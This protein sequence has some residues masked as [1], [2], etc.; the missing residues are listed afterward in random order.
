MSLNRHALHTQTY[1]CFSDDCLEQRQ[2]ARY[3]LFYCPKVFLERG[4]TGGKG[5]DNLSGGEESEKKQ[6]KTKCRNTDYLLSAK[7]VIDRIF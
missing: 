7:S 5:D 4:W 6:L 2:G 1:C 3:E